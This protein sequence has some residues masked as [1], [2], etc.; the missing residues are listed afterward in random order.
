M[1]GTERRK[2]ILLRAHESQGKTGMCE[3]PGRSESS[4]ESCKIQ[5]AASTLDVREDSPEDI[6]STALSK[7]VWFF[8]TIIEN[9]AIRIKILESGKS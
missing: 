6:L 1:N 9:F 7:C 3:A 8:G 4:H 2:H 5:A